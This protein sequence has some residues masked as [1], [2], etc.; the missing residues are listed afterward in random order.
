MNNITN[1]Q[2]NASCKDAF[3]KRELVLETFCCENK[4]E[5]GPIRAVCVIFP[6]MLHRVHGD[7]PEIVFQLWKT[8]ETIP[9]AVNEG[10]SDY[11]YTMRPCDRSDIMLTFFFGV[12]NLHICRDFDQSQVE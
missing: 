6:N 8:P 3:H 1:D 7:D 5:D 12:L 9:Q 4:R 2:V 10:S 11:I